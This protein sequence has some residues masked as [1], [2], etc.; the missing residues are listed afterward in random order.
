MPIPR[1]FPQIVFRQ[2]ASGWQGC[3]SGKRLSLSYLQRRAALILL[4]LKKRNGFTFAVVSFY[5]FRGKSFGRRRLLI[6]L[7]IG[8]EF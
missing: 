2:F 4:V 5:H 6:G 1:V 3:S 8:D 7:E